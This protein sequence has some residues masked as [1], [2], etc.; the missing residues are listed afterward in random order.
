MVFKPH[1]IIPPMI[2]PFDE[3]EELNVEG[4]REIVRFLIENGVHG[5][6]PSGSQG[7]FWALSKDEK[8]ILWK[9]VIDEVNGK[10]PVY[11][12]IGAESTRETLELG[13][14]AVDLG[15]D[16]VSV[17]TPYY[18]KPNDEELFKHYSI[19]ASKL[20][21]PIMV[22]NNPDRTGG[23]NISPRVLA[24][25]SEE[26]ENIVGIKD[27]SGDLTNTEEYIRNCPRISVLAGRDTLIFATLVLG[28]RGAVAASANVVPKLV[29]S[30][31]E[32]FIKGNMD[33][34]LNAQFKLNPLRLAFG[35]GS[36]PATI[37]E[38]ANMI[39]LPAGPVRNPINP[40]KPDKRK[41]LAK[42]LTEV[43]GLK[44]VKE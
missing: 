34:A 7:E 9:T 37:K 1:G 35:L 42:I 26:H 6:F 27:S 39:G 28:G 16:C 40:L 20:D 3:R 4:V 15:C 2:T 31:Y 36:F 30:I 22:Y 23:V 14:L 25:L 32:E 12:G 29:V 24:K 33:K 41:E 44:I 38:A 18:I 5:I 19:I 17:I 21:V 43:Y 13:R 11:L 10:V 8:E